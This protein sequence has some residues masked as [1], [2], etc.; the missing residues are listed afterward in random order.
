MTT[1][2]FH[3]KGREGKQKQKK[4][5]LTGEGGK[6]GNNLRFHV[7]RPFH[8]NC[9]VS[10]SCF[11][12]WL[13]LLLL[14]W[15]INKISFTGVF[16]HLDPLMSTQNATFPFIRTLVS[17]FSPVLALCFALCPLLDH[18][19]P[20]I[21][22]L[23]ICYRS[24]FFLWTITTLLHLLQAS[25]HWAT[26]SWSSS[27][28][29]TTCRSR[30]PNT[31]PRSNPSLRQRKPLELEG[32]FLLCMRFLECCLCAEISV[33]SFVLAWFCLH[34]PLSIVYISETCE[35]E[36]FWLQPLISLHQF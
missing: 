8:S 27:K 3:W 23:I 24:L 28:A 36:A 33:I 31:S 22:N 4:S 12:L 6:W 35:L 2:E 5:N 29:Q 25:C 26:T 18:Q 7:C 13:K 34:S 17:L 14:Q 15:G 10:C 30:R 11:R 21:K 32:N 9:S 19:L 16:I 20:P 1:E